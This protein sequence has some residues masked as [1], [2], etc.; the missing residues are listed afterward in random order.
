MLNNSD[1][2]ST[3]YHHIYINN[4]ISAFFKGTA[5]FFASELYD[6]TKEVVISTYEKHVRHWRTRSKEA[7]EKLTPRYPY[8]VVDPSLEF[9]PDPQA[10]RFFYQYQQ[11]DRKTAASMF[12][13]VIYNDGNV[14]ISPSLTRYRGRMTLI[15][16]CSSFQE[17]IDYQIMT[18]QFFGGMDRVIK[19]LNLESYIILPDEFTSYVY[20]NDYT[21]EKYS[22]NWDDNQAD[23]YLVRNINQNK[24]CFPVESQPFFRLTSLTDGSEKYGGSADAIGEHRL[25]IELEYEIELPTS[26]IVFMNQQPE[27]CPV[28]ARI[29][30]ELVVG[31]HM[32]K[33]DHQ[34]GEQIILAPDEIFKLV[35]HEITEG[36]LEGD[37]TTSRFIIY[38]QVFYYTVTEEDIDKIENEP[39]E[40]FTIQLLEDAPDCSYVKVFSKDGEMRRGWIWKLI[41]NDVIELMGFRLQNLSEGDVIAIVYYKDYVHEVM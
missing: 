5:N 6:R 13:P 32:I 21:G 10:G 14:R 28:T 8:L 36:D 4:Y 27:G 18:Y 25:N 41:D 37:T 19:P 22:L 35:G 23:V 39:P 15:L 26:L 20:E 34:V 38:D 1:N 29:D 24:M 11:F 7:G 30:M 9:E 3:R 12:N 16:Y 17:L 40:N 2:E 31:F 33:L